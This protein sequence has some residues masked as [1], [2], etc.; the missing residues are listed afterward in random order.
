MGED[1]VSG[2][3]TATVVKAAAAAREGGSSARPAIPRHLSLVCQRPERQAVQLAIIDG[4]RIRAS[5]KYRENPYA[6][7]FL[8]HYTGSSRISSRA[9][10]SVI[11]VI[12]RPREN[13]HTLADFESALDTLISSRGRYCLLPLPSDLRYWLFPESEFTLREREKRH[14]NLRWDLEDR[15]DARAREREQAEAAFQYQVQLGRARIA[16]NFAAPEMYR[17]WYAAWNEILNEY[18]QR[19]LTRRWAARFPSLDSLDF[20]FRCTEPVWVIEM[21]LREIVRE[22]PEPVRALERLF[23]PNKLGCMT[24]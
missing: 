18:D 13:H 15:R 14:R 9:L 16:L 2:H 12:W 22:T 19:E 10:N 21:N 6:R 23:V 1:A 17:Q 7:A 11:G 24:D 3:R 5:G 8:R 4:D 20:L